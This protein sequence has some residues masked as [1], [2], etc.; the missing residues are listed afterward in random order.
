MISNQ[1]LQDTIE[2][3]RTITKVDLI[4]MDVEGRPLAK[5]VDGSVEGYEDAVARLNEIVE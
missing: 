2:G 5:T 4:V 3:I 1:I